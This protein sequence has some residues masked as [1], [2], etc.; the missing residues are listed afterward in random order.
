MLKV[1]NNFNNLQFNSHKPV[2]TKKQTKLNRL[3]KDCVSFTS[4]NTIQ[5]TKPDP[6]KTINKVAS[7]YLNVLKANFEK[8]LQ[9]LKSKV[10]N[11]LINR[12]K[13][14]NGSAGCASII[15]GKNP[16]TY[17]YEM[18]LDNSSQTIFS[19]ALHEGYHILQFENDTDQ[20]YIQICKMLA[21]EN[22]PKSE[23]A[24]NYDT[25]RTIVI[26]HILLKPYRSALNETKDFIQRAFK[27]NNYK[28]ID[29]INAEN[30]PNLNK[31]L[32]PVDLIDWFKTLPEIEHI[33]YI[34]SHAEI[35]IKAHSFCKDNNE[36]PIIY[37]RNNINT[38]KLRDIIAIKTYRE[39]AQ[40]A[41][42]ELTSRKKNN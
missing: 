33:E 28:I 8:G 26:Q 17:I 40:L 41:N 39:I 23:T 34:K 7:D 19:S 10:P 4:H 32:L 12:T 27:M 24:I 36:K 1:F 21:R 29:Q 35:E 5:H 30:I 9:F 37:G 16:G 31:P 22:N 25:L 3:N 6:Y 13:F 20:K 42:N 18:D 2:Y 38:D 14:N 15:S 11:L